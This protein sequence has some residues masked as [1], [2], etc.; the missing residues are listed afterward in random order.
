ME[1]KKRLW[2]LT[3]YILLALIVCTGLARQFQRMLLPQVA[4]VPLQAG[5]ITH[6]D[7][8]PAVFGEAGAG[9]VSWQMD[10]DGYARYGENQKASL[11]WTDKDGESRTEVLKIAWQTQNP[12]GTWNF[13]MD[14]GKLSEE[15]LENA[16]ISVWM[17]R[18]AEYAYTVPLSAVSMNADGY[19]VY[20][21][22]T[23]QGVFS[24]EQIVQGMPVEVLDQDGTL[25]AVSAGWADYVVAYTSKPLQ[26]RMQVVTAE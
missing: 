19:V 7:A 23:H 5:T 13:A 22:E 9:L 6:A 25:A 26:D 11:A 8:Y 3:G 24:D 17:E 15:L 16:D 18:S 21:I 12:D 20:M 4:A 14:A 2:K 10:E 1:R